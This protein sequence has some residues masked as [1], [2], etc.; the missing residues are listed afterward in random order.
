LQNE[1]IIYNNT[2]KEISSG[3]DLDRK[4]VSNLIND[5]IHYKIKTIF[6]TNKDRLTRLSF[7]TLENI[8]NKFGTNIIVINDS[9][10]DT[11]NEVF[12]ELISLMHSFS[13]KMYSNRRKKKLTNMKN[14]L[15]LFKTLE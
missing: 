5:V 6:I 10:K 14:D 12:E 11:D 7:R 15:T 13:T 3:L 9:D 2:Y 8:F 1:Y 4:E